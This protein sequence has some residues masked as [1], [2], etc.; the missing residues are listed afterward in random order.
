MV[1][2]ATFSLNVQNIAHTNVNGGKPGALLDGHIYLIYLLVL[3]FDHWCLCFA[4]NRRKLMLWA[5]I[6]RTLKTPSRIKVSKEVS[7]Y[8][9]KDKSRKSG[10][11]RYRNRP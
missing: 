1:N 2:H 6:Y 5:K 9:K 3:L 10:L 4:G 11:S 7:P 8:A